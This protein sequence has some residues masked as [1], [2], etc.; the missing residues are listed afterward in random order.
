MPQPNHTL[1]L[2]FTAEHFP[3]SSTFALFLELAVF[4]TSSIPPNLDWGDQVTEKMHAP[5]ASLPEFRKIV[6]DVANR[7]FNTP[8]GRDLTM[9]AYNLFGDLLVGNPR[10]LGHLQGARRH[11]FV[12]SA[13]RHGGS[14]LTKELYRAVGI[15]PAQ[16]PNY[17]AHDGYPDCGLSWYT[18]RDGQDVPATRTT[19]QQT[20]EWV[21]MA[22]YFFRDRGRPMPT[23]RQ[24]DALPTFVKKGTKMV[25][26]GPFFRETFGPLSE[27]AVIVRHPVPA[28]VSLYEK[29]GGLPTDGKFPTRPRSAIERWVL[30]AWLNEGV[31]PEKVGEMPYF[32]AYLHYWM[33]YHQALAA[34]GLLNPGKQRLT[35][36]GYSPDE[37]EG[38]V[39]AQ[40]DRFGVAENP[41]PEKFH[42]SDKAR[43]RHPDWILEA[44][45]VIA[46]MRSL[47][48]SFGLELPNAASEAI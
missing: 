12:I 44:E 27:W 46:G 1:G 40:L 10:T 29:A 14:Y 37:L 19:I 35:I 33:R 32:A 16:V 5:G 20:A 43:N 11:I 24:L 45:P 17:L 2:Q 48:E 15:D 8:L 21:V 36:L 26:Q 18:Q 9:R 28:C 39:R 31:P 41:E 23:T 22:D 47:W 25:Y 6:R 34:G 42:A 38:F 4:G 7:A 13:P 30:D 3:V